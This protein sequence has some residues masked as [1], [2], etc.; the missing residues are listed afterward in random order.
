M[1]SRTQSWFRIQLQY[2]ILFRIYV[3]AAT[4]YVQQ[5]FQRSTCSRPRLR[6]RTSTLRGATNHT[7]AQFLESRRRRHARAA[8][9]H[10]TTSDWA[11]LTTSQ[12]IMSS[13]CC[14]SQRKERKTQSQS[15]RSDPVPEVMWRRGTLGGPGADGEGGS[16]TNVSQPTN[17]KLRWLC[18]W[19]R[20]KE[21]ALGFTDR[22]QI[23]QSAWWNRDRWKTETRLT[24]TFYPAKV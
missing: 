19:G 15:T 16:L 6:L 7:G 18:H 11:H 3:D 9:T 4:A 5:V 17:Q 2:K 10:H 21:S 12:S 1:I 24:S 23:P 14:R 13:V 8:L 22:G 20:D